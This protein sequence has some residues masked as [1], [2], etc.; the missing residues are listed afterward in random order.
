MSLTKDLRK[1][2]TLAVYDHKDMTK[3]AN[4]VMKSIK[5]VEK[6]LDS[7]GKPKESKK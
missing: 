4:Q 2:I 7:W 5:E 1:K 3:R 6:T